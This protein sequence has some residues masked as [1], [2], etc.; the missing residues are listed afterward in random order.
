MTLHMRDKR[1]APSP[2]GAARAPRS[3]VARAAPLPRA[4]GRAGLY[5]GGRQAG[6]RAGGR[7]A[8]RRRGG[9]V[10]CGGGR[11]AAAAG[12]AMAVARRRRPR[13]RAALATRAIAAAAAAVAAGR[14]AWPPAAAAVSAAAADAAPSAKQ[15][16]RAPE[17]G[18]ARELSTASRSGGGRGGLGPWR[19]PSWSDRGKGG[20]GG[21]LGGTQRRLECTTLIVAAARAHDVLV[22]E[23]GC[24]CMTGRWPQEARAERQPAPRR[25]RWSARLPSRP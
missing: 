2:R 19:R 23:R 24:R 10:G 5:P 14:A 6:G 12:G 22:D 20:E 11:A 15:Q 8:A 7:A 16:P 9:R 4:Q 13:L 1:A 21:G 18:V 17:E 25:W 3:V